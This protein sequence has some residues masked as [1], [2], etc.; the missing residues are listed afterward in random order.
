MRLDRRLTQ[1][2]GKGEVI[3]TFGSRQSSGCFSQEK[4]STQ[5]LA[6]RR[7]QLHC[8]LC[9]WNSIVLEIAF[10]KISRRRQR[11]VPEVF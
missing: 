4:I 9:K 1:M 10:L 7:G 3:L 5:I 11:K 8:D 6:K 2:I